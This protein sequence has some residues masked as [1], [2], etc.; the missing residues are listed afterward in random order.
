MSVPIRLTRVG[1]EPNMLVTL[2]VLGKSRAVSR[3]Y[4]DVCSNPLLARP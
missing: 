4:R 3:N 1:A 2:W